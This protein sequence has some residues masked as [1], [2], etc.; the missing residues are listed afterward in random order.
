MRIDFNPTIQNPALQ[1]LGS[2]IGRG[3]R[4]PGELGDVNG[5]L[6]GNNPEPDPD[7]LKTLMDVIKEVNVS[8]QKS[9]TIQNDLMT[10]QQV[11]YHDLMIA[12]EKASVSMQLTIAV[13]NKIL[14]AYQEISRMPV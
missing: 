12:M 9:S 7:F 8:Q 1:D 2:N 4:G 3:L 13:R 11:D 10:G 14:E 5:L 6:K